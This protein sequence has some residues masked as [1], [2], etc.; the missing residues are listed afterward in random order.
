MGRERDHAHAVFGIVVTGAFRG[1]LEAR[2]NHLNLPPN[3]HAVVDAK[4]DRLAGAE[5]PAG[6]DESTRSGVERAIDGA[7][8]DGFR[9][10]MLLGAALALASVFVAWLLIEGKAPR[11]AD[12]P[13]RGRPATAATADG[14]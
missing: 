12:R 10:I 5:P 1:G 8:V 2:L 9:V 6:V 3:A 7:C 14:D 4:R 11:H 13:A